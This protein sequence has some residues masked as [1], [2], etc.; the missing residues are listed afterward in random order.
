MTFVLAQWV[1]AALVLIS[2]I[3]VYWALGGQWATDVVIPQIPGREGQGLRPAFKPSAL[4]TLAVAVGLLLVA[5][6]QGVFAAAGFGLLTAFAVAGRLHPRL[7]TLR[8]SSGGVS[9][10]PSARSPEAPLPGE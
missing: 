7:G 3:H 6:L 9:A 4:L 5:P 10:S 1:A 2:L 8:P